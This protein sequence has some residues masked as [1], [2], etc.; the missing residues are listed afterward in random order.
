[1]VEEPSR[2]EVTLR[3]IVEG[4]K[5]EAYVEARTKDMRVCW[6]CGTVSYKKTPMKLVGSRW[7]CIDC[8]RQVR[9]VIATM[10]QWEAEVQLEREMSRKIDQGLG[11]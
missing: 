6:L 7:V 3:S 9:E 1:M 4:R 2:Q 8:F 10:D 11:L 5:M